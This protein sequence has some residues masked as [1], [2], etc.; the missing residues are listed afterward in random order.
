M[1]PPLSQIT[2]ISN[3]EHYTWGDRCDGWH[4]VKSE[5]LSVIRETMPPQT[6]EQRHYHEK[7]QQFFYILSG[8]ATFEIEGNLYEVEQN[9]GML[10]Q[11]G[12]RHRI[13]NRTAT[14]LEFLVISQPH[15][16]GDRINLEDNS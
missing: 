16:H 9:K 14:D 10:I 5:N 11:P 4:F 3:S 13:S 8:T 12:T 15:A 7:A 1:E 2:D 6:K